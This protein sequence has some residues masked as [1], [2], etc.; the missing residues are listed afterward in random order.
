[1]DNSAVRSFS[2]HFVWSGF[3]FDWSRE[4]AVFAGECSCKEGKGTALYGEFATPFY[5]IWNQ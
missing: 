1:M 2:E 4:L 5:M 3:V